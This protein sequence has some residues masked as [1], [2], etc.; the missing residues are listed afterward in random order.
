MDLFDQRDEDG[1]VELLDAEPGPDQYDNAR[2]AA[3]ACPS[4]AIDIQD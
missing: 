1:V 3:A 4:L 2:A